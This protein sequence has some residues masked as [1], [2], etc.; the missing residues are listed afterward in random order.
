MSDTPKDLPGGLQNLKT[1]VEQKVEEL[2][3]RL[4]DVERRLAERA[5]LARERVDEPSDESD[6]S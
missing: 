4:A 6:A 5:R 3:R 1:E 2:E